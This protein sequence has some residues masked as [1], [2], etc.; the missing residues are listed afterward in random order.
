MILIVD[1]DP[2]VLA[3][4]SLLLKQAGFVSHVVSGPANAQSW[5]AS[6][7][8]Q[9]VLQDMNFT[10]QTTGEEGLSLLTAIRAAHPQLPVVL[11]TA[12][13]SIDLAVRGM[14]AGASDFI[15]K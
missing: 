9:L 5:L 6:H 13:G 1:D 12:W 3:S 4:L 14:K 2:S 11:I 15:T 7:P 8:C 10:R